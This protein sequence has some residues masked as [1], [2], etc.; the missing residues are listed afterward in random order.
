[1]QNFIVPGHEN[2]V[3]LVKY[4]TFNN[5]KKIFT[6]Y[7]DR[8]F[9]M[10]PEEVEAERVRLKEEVKRYPDHMMTGVK[11]QIFENATKTKL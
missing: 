8:V 11:I 3:D 4:R 1:M 9:K 2:V 6:G 5:A 10:H 7:K